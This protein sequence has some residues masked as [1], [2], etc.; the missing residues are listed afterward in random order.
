MGIEDDGLA[1]LNSFGSA[2]KKDKSSGQLSLSL[3]P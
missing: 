2:N 1:K 3:L